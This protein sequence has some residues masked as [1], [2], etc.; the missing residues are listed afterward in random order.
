[1]RI[2]VERQNNNQDALGVGGQS[3]ESRAYSQDRHNTEFRI[4]ESGLFGKYRND[5]RVQYEESVAAFSSFSNAIATNVQ[6]NF[7]SGGAQMAGGTRAREV[8]VSDDLD[9]ALNKQHAMR[10]GFRID[11]GNYFSDATQNTAGTFTYRSLAAYEGGLP[12]QYA[13]RRGDPVINYSNVQAAFYV[14]DDYKL[15]KNVMLSLG[16]RYEGQ[17]HV[18][19]WNNIAP[20]ISTTWSPFKSNRTT[21]RAGFGIFYDWYGTSTYSQT[22]Q[23]DGEHQ[24]D[25]IIQNPSL[26]DPLNSGTG[27]PLAPS[28]V[29][30]AENLSLPT[31][32]RFSVGV[33]QQ[34]TSWLR[35][36]TNYF[37]QH[38][39][40]ELRSLNANYPVSGT[41]PDTDLGNISEIQSIGKSDSQGVDFGFNIMMPQRK[42]FAFINY[43]LA[44]A[45]D[46]G[47]SLTLSPSNT[48][49]TEW[50]YA[51]TD[52][53][54]RLFAM[55]T[56]PVW[57]ALRANTNIRYQ[58]GPRYNV[59]AGVDT[60]LDGNFNERPAGFAR[61]SGR[62]DGQ[63]VMDLRLGW[64]IGFGPDKPQTPGRG[65]GGGGPRII[66]GPGPGGGGPG[67]GGGGGG[68]MGG[69][70]GGGDSNKRYT[71]EIFT[72]ANNLLNHAVYTSYVGVITS[73]QFGLPTSTQPPRRIEVGTRFGF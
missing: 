38:G 30:Q 50:G 21:V 39:W 54:H 26:T 23:L 61:N 72:Q 51:S 12:A 64:T 52:I 46:D 11:G 33:D 19:D 71:V 55:F 59:T 58:S 10:I 42:L 69:G 22:I 9:F 3:L 20:R 15:R 60:N 34:I 1:L 68:M 70:P 36:R 16:A 24:Y 6:G 31:I 27:I 63:L 32:R 4:S 2:E 47:S 35:V 17:T 66:Q 43:T 45:K 67:G 13:I 53:R 40:N 18:D 57:K 41:R 56:T 5:I 7:V 62:G 25:E 65:P 28:I 48:L 44:S 73:G 37:N 49:A 14:T 8:Q 29:R